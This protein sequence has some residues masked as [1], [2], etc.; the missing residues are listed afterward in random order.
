MWGQKSLKKWYNNL[1]PSPSPV[2]RRRET[3]IKLSFSS[4]CNGEELEVR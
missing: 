4:P 3:L 1:I 2:N